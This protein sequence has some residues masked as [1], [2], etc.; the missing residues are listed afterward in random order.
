M[1][2]FEITYAL[3]YVMI[4]LINLDS[5]MVD[6]CFHQ[7]FPDLT[8]NLEYINTELTSWKSIWL[9]GIKCFF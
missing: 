1:D 5:I 8:Y 7:R 4:K 3:D 6:M 9:K 2:D